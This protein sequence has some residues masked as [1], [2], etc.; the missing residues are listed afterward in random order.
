MRYTVR[1][2]PGAKRAA[3]S[4]A[5]EQ[6]TVETP[7]RAH[8]NEANQAVIDLLAKH[9]RIAKGNITILKGQKSKEKIIEILG[10][11]SQT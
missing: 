5:G 6:I 1:V 11:T 8:D 10:N 4:I 3:V 9:F 2:K 7:K